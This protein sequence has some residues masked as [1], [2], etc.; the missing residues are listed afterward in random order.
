VEEAQSSIIDIGALIDSRPL[1]MFQIGIMLMIGCSVV[2]DGFDVQTMGFVA[3]AIVQAWHISPADL[4]PVFGAGLLGMLAGSIVLGAMADRIGRQPVLVGATVFYG[5]C[6]LGTSVVQSIPA[7]LVVRFLTG[8]GIGGVMGNAIALV[9]EYSPRK[10]R[11]SMMTWV[12]CGFTGG[13]IAGGLLCAVMLP[14]MGW[15]SVFVVGG[16]LPLVIAVA[17]LRYLPESLQLLVLK[18]RSPEKVAH[19]LAKIAPGIQIGPATRFAIHEQTRAKAS[20]G[21]LFRHGRGAM[22]LLLWGINFANLLNLFFLSNWLPML[23]LRVGHGVSAA[24]LM[25]TSL[26]I[27]GTVGALLMGPLMDR[28]GFYRVLTIGF[29]VATFSVSSIGLP[30]LSTALRYA[31]VLISGI[32]IVGGQPAVNALT[33]TL[34]PT[35]LRAT[36]VGWSLGIGRAGSIIGPVVAG[37][38][39]RLEWSNTALFAAAAVPALASCVML[40][41]LS[42]TVGTGRLGCVECRVATTGDGTEATRSR[43]T[44]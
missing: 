10:Y 44:V 30:D 25:G 16:I 38:L 15:R 7:F 19:W 14:S 27:G 41:F 18:Q 23:S 28:F 35:S 20:A 6:M 31:V 22:T 32:C 12:S 40:V 17:M 29:L 42:R 11:A 8:F 43:R 36:G 39:I 13:A 21:E 26:Q 4:G 33:A 37:Q 24:V 5:L 1:S 9:S 2:M 34:Y 3:P